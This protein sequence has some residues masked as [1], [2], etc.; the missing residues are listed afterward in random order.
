MT[1]S[2]GTACPLRAAPAGTG[3]WQ[4]GRA[5]GQGLAG[6]AA[7]HVGCPG[8][9]RTK[10]TRAQQA[11]F[12]VGATSPAARCPLPCP[13]RR[14]RSRPVPP[15]PRASRGRTRHARGQRR[16]WH[17]GKEPRPPPAAAVGS[18]SLPT[19]PLH[20]KPLRT[21]GKPG[22]SSPVEAQ[23]RHKRVPR[24]LWRG[25]VLAQLPAW[26]LGCRDPLPT[27]PP[28]LPRRLFPAA[29][30]GPQ[31]LGRKRGQSPAPRRW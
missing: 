31:K 6:R 3:S 20:P 25:K 5:A 21:E 30:L 13:A 10:R 28:A 16:R 27:S 8:R 1:L 18:W 19:T 14:G 29:R 2:K 7:P 17:R 26:S 15:R 11:A 23:W 4:R 9:T 22:G 12:C 24:I